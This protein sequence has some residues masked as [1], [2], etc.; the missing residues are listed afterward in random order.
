MTL[1]ALLHTGAAAAIASAMMFAAFPSAATAAERGPRWGREDAPRMERQSRQERPQRTMRAPVQ[2]Q[3]APP[4]RRAEQRAPVVQ[5]RSGGNWNR[6]DRGTRTWNRSDSRP[7]DT[8]TD[9]QQ[10]GVPAWDRS[11]RNRS[12]TDNNRNR[13]YSGRDGDRRNNWRD[14]RRTDNRSRGT[15]NR[16]NRH[17]NGNR[18]TWNRDRNGWDH[19]RDSRR[20]SRNWRSNSHYDWHHYRSHNRSVF[21]IGRYYAPYNGYR[22]SRVGIGF[23]LNNLFFSSRYWINDPGYY[24]LPPAYG[25][26][27]WVRYYDDVLLVDIYSGEVVDVIHNFFW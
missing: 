10:A 19:R 2:T 22:Y 23:Y 9:A 7:A 16:D 11:G 21:R 17:W 25:P 18:Q 5:Q 12:Y 4:Q 14:N 27:R 6:N 8:R 3:T 1:K 20:W 13:T 24:R 15:Y 26:Y